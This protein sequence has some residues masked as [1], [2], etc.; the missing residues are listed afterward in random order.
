MSSPADGRNNASSTAQS[1]M[2]NTT[3]NTRCKPHR[4]NSSTSSSTKS[5]SS[6]GSVHKYLGDRKISSI[7]AWNTGVPTK[8]TRPHSMPQEHDPIVQAYLQTKMA[9]FESIAKHKNS[10][11]S[12]RM[13]KIGERGERATRHKLNDSSCVVAFL[14][15]IIIRYTNSAVT[16]DLMSKP[17]ACRLTPQH[18]VTQPKDF[19]RIQSFID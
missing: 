7:E 10:S 14:D 19:C 16:P 1:D 2:R 5:T 11:Q 13:G 15:G 8:S 6:T 18:E 12:S 4:T 17:Q 9:L 3:R